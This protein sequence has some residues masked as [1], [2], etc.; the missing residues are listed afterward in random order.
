MEWFTIDYF[1]EEVLATDYLDGV[2]V[3]FFPHLHPQD[4]PHVFITGWRVEPQRGDMD[5]PNFRKLKP[6]LPVYGLELR[7]K[8]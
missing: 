8:E 2:L 3:R 4:D 5:G 7:E 1:G 6:R